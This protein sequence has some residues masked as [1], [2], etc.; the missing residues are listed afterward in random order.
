V[1][2]LDAR[3]QL[4]A[5][6]DVIGRAR[7]DDLDVPVAREMLGDIAGV[8]LGAAVDRL[9]VPLNDDGDLHCASVSSGGRE[10]GTDAGSVVPASA[11]GAGVSSPS[12]CSC[13]DA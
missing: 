11:G 1:H 6:G 9:S 12:A 13:S 4:V 5:P 3:L 2:L 8:Q 10:S 7:R